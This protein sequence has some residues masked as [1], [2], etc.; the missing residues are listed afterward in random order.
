MSILSRQTYYIDTENTGL[1]SEFR[2]II[3]K[4]ENMKSLLSVLTF[5]VVITVLAGIAISP[6]AFVGFLF[7]YSLDVYFEKD[8][9]W[10]GDVLVGTFS[11]PVLIP[12]AVVGYV[13]IECDHTKPII[14]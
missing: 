14:K 6:F 2:I 10:Y 1:D 12:A 4:G 3:S 7:D 13:L 11:S 5:V 8:I 9:P